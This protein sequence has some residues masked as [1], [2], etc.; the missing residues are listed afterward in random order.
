MRIEGMLIDLDG[1]IYTGDVPVP[2]AAPALA[3]LRD[4]DI[5]FRFVSNTTRR[6]RETIAARLRSMG[7]IVDV[8]EIF[9]PAVAAAAWLS[10]KGYYSCNVL[11]TGDMDRDLLAAGLSLTSDDP[12]AVVIGDAGDAFTYQA[13]T[14]AF[15]DLL[16]GAA[17]VALE[18]DRY[19]MGTGGLMLSA[20]PF[21]KAL[22]Y[23]ASTE[24]VLIGK[25][26][27]AFF[28]MALESIGIGVAEAAMAGDDVITDTGGA[29]QAGMKGILVRTGKYRD[30][31]LRTASVRPDYIIGSIAELPALLA[32]EADA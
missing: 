7:F 32:R 27:G 18:V 11:F 20:G 16:Q 4:Q 3:Y 2:G 10:K 30:D 14:R 19:W 1:V 9:T 31:A 12:S 28:A 22:E 29:M 24:A 8:S 13:M 23:A 25:P 15:R 26:S 21:V 6:C 17:L 5:P